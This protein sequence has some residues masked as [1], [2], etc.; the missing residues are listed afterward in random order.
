ME[1]QSWKNSF[2]QTVLEKLENS[3]RNLEKQSWRNW[4]NS[5]GK[6]GKTVLEKLEKQSWK[7][8]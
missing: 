8:C 2:R 7:N 3:L 1:K 4:K 5:H 6:I